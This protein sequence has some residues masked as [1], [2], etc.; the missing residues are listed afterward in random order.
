M[1]D[2]TPEQPPEQPSPARDLIAFTPV[3]RE[4]DRSNGWKP[5]VQRAFI[6][7]LADTGSVKAA[8]RAVGRADHGAYRLRRHPEGAEFAAA[9]DAALDHGIRRIEDVAMDRALNGVDVPVYSYGKL[10]GMRT[11]YN[12]RLLMFMLRNRAS[13]RFN[14]GSLRARGPNA[15]DKMEL[16]RARKEWQA[17][18]DREEDEARAGATDVIDQIKAM[19]VRWWSTL[20]PRTRAAYVHFRRIERLEDRRW[21]DDEEDVEAAIA[22]AEAEYAEVFAGDGRC[23]ALLLGEMEAIGDEVTCPE[24]AGGEETEGDGPQASPPREDGSPPG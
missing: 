2:R 13:E 16:E 20:S 21:L 10:V 23:R 12:D 5:E 1:S 9:W 11:V 15:I 6:E 7:A 24:I 18:R 4:K 14:A 17:E 19:H 3:P 22:A 8:C